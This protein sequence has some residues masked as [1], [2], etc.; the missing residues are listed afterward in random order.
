MYDPFIFSA[1][2]GGKFFTQK[3]HPKHSR[4]QNTVHLSNL[5]LAW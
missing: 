3:A 2:R 4:H 1:K 5:C